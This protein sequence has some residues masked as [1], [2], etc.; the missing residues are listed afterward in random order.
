MLRVVCLLLARV[1]SDSSHAAAAEQV[2]WLGR[3]P[4]GGR[5]NRKDT[6]SGAWLQSVER[7]LLVKLDRIGNVEGA[8]DTS[9]R[10]HGG[11]DVIETVDYLDFSIE[12]LS[13]YWR[14]AGPTAYARTQAQLE[15]FSARLKR[16]GN[17]P[18]RHG[19]DALREDTVCVMPFYASRDDENLARAVLA[20]TVASLDVVFGRIVVTVSTPFDEALAR[21]VRGPNSAAFE[22][23][24]LDSRGS[25]MLPKATL[26]GLQRALRG[27]GGANEWLGGTRPRY[28]YFTESDSVVH[29]RRPAAVRATLDAGPKSTIIVPHRLQGIPEP[30]NEGSNVSVTWV[31]AGDSCLD[32]A[33]YPGFAP[34]WPKC[35]N[36]WYRCGGGRIA[37]YGLLRLRYGTGLT[38]LSGTEHGRQCKLAPIA[39][40]PGS[41]RRRQRSAAAHSLPASHLAGTL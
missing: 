41:A 39:P 2:R 13:T 28:V 37:A 9:V 5:L 40:Q 31:D 20:A 24:R 11:S 16:H 3:G 29:V 34:H 19:A 10:L 17:T 38:L 35:D 4:A 12:H 23:L 6:Y 27:Q 26:A 25:K 32:T 33:S 15:R 36:F 7:F 8:S 1:R 21:D 30:A 14:M 18:R 22:V